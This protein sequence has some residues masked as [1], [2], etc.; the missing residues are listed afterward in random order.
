MTRQESEKIVESLMN[1]MDNLSAL[2]L[3]SKC[4]VNVVWNSALQRAIEIIQNMEVDEI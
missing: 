1:E 3:L 4:G 2:K